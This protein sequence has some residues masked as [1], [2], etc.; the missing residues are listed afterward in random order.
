MNSRLTHVCFEFIRCLSLAFTPRSESFFSTVDSQLSGQSLRNSSPLRHNKVPSFARVALWSRHLS[1]SPRSQGQTDQCESHP[2][3]RIR[4]SCFRPTWIAS[5]SSFRMACVILM[6]ML[7]TGALSMV[8]NRTIDDQLGDSVTGERAVYLPNTIW[9]LGSECAGCFARPDPA[10]TFDHSQ[11][12]SLDMLASLY[13]AYSSAWH[14]ATIHSD[15]PRFTELNI[16][17]K[18]TGEC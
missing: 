2:L 8:S 16:S 1:P 9:T 4:P 5:L 15:E 6:L 10:R 17:M 13:S 14:D 12:D 3:S 7:L 18:F 11:F